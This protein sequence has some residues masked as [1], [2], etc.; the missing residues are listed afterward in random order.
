V[1]E[2]L[3]RSGRAENQAR[4]DELERLLAQKDRQL[5]ESEQRYREFH[6]R[7][8]NDLAGLDMHAHSQWQTAGQPEPCSKCIA[9]LDATIELYGLLDKIGPGQA[10]KIRVA[11]YLQKVAQ[12][13]QRAFAGNL[14]IET[15][16]DPLVSLRRER[17]SLIG[18]IFHEAIAN[19]LK[20][21]FPRGSHGTVRTSFR[22]VGNGYELVVADD[23]VGFDPEGVKKGVGTQVMRHLA[24]QLN[25]TM[26]YAKVPKGSELHLSFPA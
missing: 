9:R 20:Y 5:R 4:I 22:R 17:A 15:S 8:M 18:L 1:L 12:T 2:A 25:G 24:Q 26:H 10:P 3:Q 6:H 16:L 23:G 13:L 14:K 19:A 21:A 11:P 7:V